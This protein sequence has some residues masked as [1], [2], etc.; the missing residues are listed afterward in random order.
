MLLSRHGGPAINE[1]QAKRIRK[2]IEGALLSAGIMFPNCYDRKLNAHAVDSR[3]Y[4]LTDPETGEV[5]EGKALQWRLDPN[6]PR[7]IY[8]QVKRRVQAFR[9]KGRSRLLSEIRNRITRRTVS[10]ME[11]ART[12]AL[13]RE[14]EAVPGVQRMGLSNRTEGS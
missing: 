10:A 9:G 14:Y 12:A 7:G 6:C 11:H 1:K 8:R 4:E 13:Q 2:A 5:R 3:K